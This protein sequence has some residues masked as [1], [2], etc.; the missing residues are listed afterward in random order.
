M[1]RYVK[2]RYNALWLHLVFH[3]VVKLCNKVDEAM[4]HRVTL[5]SV[6]PFLV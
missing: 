5:C 1:L 6:I 3:L 2:A 4:L